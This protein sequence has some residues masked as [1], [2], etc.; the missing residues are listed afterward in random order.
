MADD[1]R[2]QIVGPIH[3]PPLGHRDP[4]QFPDGPAAGD[5]AGLFVLTPALPELIEAAEYAN[6]NCSVGPLV[7]TEQAKSQ[8]CLAG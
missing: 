6:G 1:D 3:E 2:A 7:T 5:E 4:P 8:L